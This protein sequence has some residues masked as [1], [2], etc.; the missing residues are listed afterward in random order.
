MT[1]GELA[2][3]Y[4]G[5][6]LLQGGGPARLHVV[7]MTGWKRTMWLDQTGLPWR[8]PSPNLLT[9]QS[10]TAYIGTCLLEA[11]NVSEGRGSPAPFEMI[12][13]PWLDHV[14]AARLLNALALPGVRFDTVTFT[15][16]QQPFHSRPPELAGQSLKGIQLR[17]T[18]RDAFQPYR[19][20]IALVWAVHRL[21]ADRLVWNDAVLD[22]LVATPR[23][24]AMITAG[25]TPAE[26]YTS[27]EREV[28]EFRE[29][30]ARYLIY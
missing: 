22:R 16:T 14:E 5:E 18:D 30:R 8:K 25:K 12:G 24:K 3:L 27:W 19:A 23:L 26:I 15:P 28:A 17:V 2:L 21:H 11:L 7:P 13:A 9:L 6:R 10:L 4:N 1:M 29:L 20:G